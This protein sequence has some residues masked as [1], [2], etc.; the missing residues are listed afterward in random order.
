MSDEL[1]ITTLAMGSMIDAFLVSHLP[2]CPETDYVRIRMAKAHTPKPATDEAIAPVRP[3]VVKPQVALPSVAKNGTYQPSA[4]KQIS[5]QPDEC[6]AEARNIIIETVEAKCEMPLPALE[7]LT[8]L[9]GDRLRR[10]IE[11]TIADYVQVKHI[12]PAKG[13]EPVKPKRKYTRSPEAKAN[14]RA[15]IKAYWDRRR[16]EKNASV[17]A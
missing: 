11:S 5:A 12:D 17:A 13:E 16:A 4:T 14:S 6:L 1:S 10:F 15:G 7:V 8:K 9:S 3:T 2:N